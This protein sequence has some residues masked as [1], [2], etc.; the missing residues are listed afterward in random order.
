MLR[1]SSTNVGFWLQ[2]AT[3]VVAL[4]VVGFVRDLEKKLDNQQYVLCQALN[5]A[6]S[7]AFSS[8]EGNPGA[9]A[10]EV[11]KINRSMERLHCAERGFPEI[12]EP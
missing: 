5:D 8:L 1:I 9:Q 11:G 10:R 7:R 6:R 12:F 4:F 3:I 2:V